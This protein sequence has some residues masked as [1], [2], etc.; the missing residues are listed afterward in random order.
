MR[1]YLYD[2]LS[3]LTFCKPSNSE[4]DRYKFEGKILFYPLRIYREEHL[5]ETVRASVEVE[6]RKLKF[7]IQ[8]FNYNE[9]FDPGSG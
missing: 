3:S 5:A 1:T 8:T 9:E 6:R 2:R 7:D 4:N